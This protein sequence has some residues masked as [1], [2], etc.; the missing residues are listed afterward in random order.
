[1]KRRLFPRALGAVVAA[2]ALLATAAPAMAGSP[3]GTLDWGPCADSDAIAAGWQCATFKAPKDYGN[4][5]AGFVK[6]AVTRLPAQDEA[7]RVGAMFINYGGPGGTAVD[8]TQAIGT[9]LF[10]AVNDRFDLVA[11]DPRGVGQSS[12][13]IDC[14]VNQETEGL[15]SKPFTTPENLD[16]KALLAKDKSY[17]KRC[18]ALNKGILPYVSTAN[19][20]RDMDGI[21]EAMGDRKLNYFGFSYGTFL[22]ATYASLFP[23]N[24]RAMVLDGPVDANG[25]INTPSANLRE[26]S[27]GFERAIGRFFTACAVFQS[28]CNFGGSDPQAAYDALVDSANLLAIPVPDGRAAVNGDDILAATALAMYAKQFWP[29]LAHALSAAASGDGTGIRDLADAFWGN[30]EDGTFDPATDRYFT[31]TAI[32]QNFTSDVQTFLDAGDNAWGVFNYTY[33]NTGYPEI[34]YALWPIHATDVFRG[35]FKA[36]KSAPT[37]L[38]IATTYDPATPFRGAKRLAKQ[39]GNVRFLTMVGDGHTAYQNG[40]PDCIDTAVVAQ[41]ETLTL[42]PEGTICQQDIPFVPPPAP[43][44]SATMSAVPLANSSFAQHLV[45]LRTLR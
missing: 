20:A 29:D 6:I 11:F 5:G 1:M 23:K 43:A 25:Y 37:I 4:P 12:P 9:D 40:S 32:E 44:T 45:R 19:V 24:Y 7:H 36:S 3:A 38:E 33:W 21:R 27:A 42:P 14:A 39:L 8:T 10:G 41:I 17:V 35:P 30:N 34:N 26:Q 2:F 13:S 22:G 18:V 31:I 28:F 16:V 15:Y